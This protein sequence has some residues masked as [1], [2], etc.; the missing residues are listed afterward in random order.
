MNT[1]GKVALYL[2]FVAFGALVGITLSG[3]FIDH[4][5]FFGGV[6]AGQLSAQQVQEIVLRDP[7]SMKEYS[8]FV[9]RGSRVFTTEGSWLMLLV[10]VLPVLV[11][12]LAVN[13]IICA[14]GNRRIRRAQ[15]GI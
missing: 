6:A 15:S 5:V 11:A 14:W 8:S 4:E 1:I 9:F 10:V 2:V 3:A 13:R 7:H 12:T